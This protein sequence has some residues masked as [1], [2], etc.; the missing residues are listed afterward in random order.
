MFLGKNNN[1]LTSNFYLHLNG[2]KTGLDRCKLC[3]E[4]LMNK[5]IEIESILY[6][7]LMNWCRWG[8]N[9]RFW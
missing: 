7:T 8:E 2:V 9:N 6:G 1:F 3:L 5:K 4:N